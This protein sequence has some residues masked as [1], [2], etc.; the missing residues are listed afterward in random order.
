MFN[1]DIAFLSLLVPWTEKSN[2]ALYE[3]VHME[4]VSGYI[5]E[6]LIKGIENINNTRVHLINKIH[7][8]SFPRKYKKFYIKKSSFNHNEI[9]P[10]KDI[11]FAFINLGIII[12]FALFPFIKKELKKWAKT[13]GNSTKIFIVYAITN[14]GIKSINYIKKINPNIKTGIIVPDLPEYMNLSMNM[15]IWKK[16]L[17]KY[18]IKYTNRLIQNNITDIDSFFIFSKHM[19]EILKCNTKHT[20]IEGVS[21]DLFLKFK[22]IQKKGAGEKIILYAGGLQEKYG[23]MNLIRAFQL[24]P[25]QS[26]KLIICGDGDAYNKIVEASEI[27]KRIVF[28]GRISRTEVLSLILESTVLINPRQNN[29]SF[30]RYSF[31]SKTLE[32][33]SSGIPLIGYKLDGIDDEYDLF[34]NYVEG[35]KII[36]LK[37]KIEEICS[38]N[39]NDLFN[40]GKAAQKFVLEEKSGTKQAIKILEAFL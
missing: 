22:K 16:L 36:D 8:G 13:E 25:N 11:S 37:N 1:Y 14:Y 40:M 34:I 15:P 23:I 4:E 7:I 28:K 38:M 19:S 31:P 33:L 29:E 17:R 5:Q 18:S 6:Q 39:D 3:K 9:Q 26:Y 32:Y 20:V 35:D 2:V 24:I 12:R 21:T 30:T 27:D 10:V